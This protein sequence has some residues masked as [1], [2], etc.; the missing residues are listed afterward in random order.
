MSSYRQVVM[1]DK[2][3][4][5]LVELLDDVRRAGPYEIG[6][7]TRQTVPR[8]YDKSHERAGLLLHESLWASVETDIPV[9]ARSVDFVDFCA[10]HFQA[11]SPVN[12]WL[13]GMPSPLG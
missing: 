5:S 13:L 2:T 12:Q 6:G 11:T 1:D 3:G 9:E 10:R 4:R 7:A 8:R